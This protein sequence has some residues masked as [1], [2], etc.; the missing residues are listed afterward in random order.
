[1]LAELHAAAQRIAAG[2][3]VLCIVGGVDSYFDAATILWLQRNSQLAMDDIPIGFSPGE[4]AG[5]VA[6]TSADALRALRASPLATVVGSHT[7]QEHCLIKTDA[8][9]LSKALT[10]AVAGAAAGLPADDALRPLMTQER[11]DEVLRTLRGPQA[12]G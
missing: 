12:A 8:I 1:M 5:F 4:G 3:L 6:L 7:A 2:T 10:A 11:C 9:N